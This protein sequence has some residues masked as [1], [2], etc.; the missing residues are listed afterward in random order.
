MPKNTQTTTQ[1]HSSYASKVILKSIQVRLHQYVNH[2]IPDMQAGFRKGRG[3]R[4]PVVN[5][6]WI[7]EKQE[8]SR[9]TST[10]ALLTTPRPLTV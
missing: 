10:S 5:I 1:F 6:R 8:S 9:K 3:T 2:E 4:N 7:P